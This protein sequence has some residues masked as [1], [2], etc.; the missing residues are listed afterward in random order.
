M[1]QSNLVSSLD[2]NAFNFDFS[3]LIPSFGNTDFSTMWNR[4]GG[5]LPNQNS[6]MSMIPGMMPVQP[7]QAPTPGVPS[8][9]EMGLRDGTLVSDVFPQYYEGPGDFS[10]LPKNYIPISTDPTGRN[11][12]TAMNGGPSWAD[13]LNQFT[14]SGSGQVPSWMSNITG[15]PDNWMQS[16][17][18]VGGGGT[19]GGGSVGAPGSPTPTFPGGSSNSSWSITPG[20]SGPDSAYLRSIVQGGGSPFN[21]MPA[22]EAM[23]AAQQRGIDQGLAQL[24]EQFGAS[25]NRFSTAFGSAAGDYM[26]QAKLD[27]NAL[28]G[29]MLMAAH[30]SAAGRQF[31]G[32]GQLAG[33]ER[34]YTVQGMQNAM[35][36]ALLQM[37][38]AARERMQQAQ[39]GFDTGQNA[40]NRELQAGLAAYSGSSDA[41][42][43]MA[44]LGAQGA[45]QMY[46]SEIGAGNLLSQ[47]MLQQ[48]GMRGDMA[49]QLG[50]LYMQ[51]L[52]LGGQLGGQQYGTL[53]GMLGNQYQEWL[54]TRPEYNPLLG[55]IGGGAFAYPNL[56]QPQYPQSN[57]GSI[58]GGL[59]GLL[60]ATPGIIG[61]IQDIFT[62]G[63]NNSGTSQGG[64]GQQGGGGGGG[65]GSTLGTILPSIIN[66]IPGIINA[67]PGLPDIPTFGR[68]GVGI[69][70]FNNGWSG[71]MDINQMVWGLSGGPMP[72]ISSGP[73][74]LY[75]NNAFQDLGML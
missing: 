41:A 68:P 6:L 30:D 31:T 2:P 39:F 59:G 53:Q 19:S 22:W 69:N 37:E 75:G 43:L 11:R 12:P 66:A 44:Q 60:G 16:F 45:G 28:L 64:G 50:S 56:F 17:M 15:M 36:Q 72:N 29:Q 67:I 34:D 5:G 71:P 54:R 10:P 1:P 52:G 61:A 57:L 55:A 9:G 73:I 38:L 14:N 4:L 65:G 42:R 21:A 62:G 24:Q 25:G 27:Q 18:G 51:N 70:N 35:Q 46:G 40:L 47:L 13:F 33:F 58:L 48:M 3:G 74:G 26:N 63:S 23:V 49:G 20:A 8:Q 7:Q 32:A